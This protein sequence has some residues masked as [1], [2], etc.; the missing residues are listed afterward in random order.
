MNE[1]KIKTKMYLRTLIFVLSIV[2]YTGSCDAFDG[3]T[4][5]LSNGSNLLKG[6]IVNNK[7]SRLSSLLESKKWGYVSWPAYDKQKNLMYIEGQNTDFGLD[8]FIFSV[9][10]KPFGEKV[11]KI[12][13]GRHPAVSM[14]GNFLAYYKHPNQLRLKGLR[15]SKDNLLVS[16]YANYQ[17]AVWADNHTLL[18]SDTSNKMMKINTS[19]RETENT[20]H[21]FVIPGSLSPT[22]DRV[23]CGSYDGT[24]IYMYTIE[25]NE[26]NVLMNSKIFS[27]GNSFVWSNNSKNFLYTKQT[28]S[29]LIRLNVARSLFLYSPKGRDTKLMNMFSLFGGN[30]L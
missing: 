28:F 15:N 16:N 23:L 6:S 24:A 21:D 18:Y 9:S 22:G 25:T 30:N 13:K 1:T 29:N 12:V 4:I 20:K 3:D 14:D 7:M 5:I 19:T 26:I 10:V 2:L 11:T 17:P 27:L 8:R